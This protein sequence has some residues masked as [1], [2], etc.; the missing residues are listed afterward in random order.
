MQWISK[1]AIMNIQLIDVDSKIPNLALMQ[2]SAYHKARG[3]HVG[4]TISD[5]DRVYISCIFKKNASQAK[6]IAKMFPESKIFLGGSGL[7]WSW[8]PKKMQKIKPDYDLYPSNY[9]LGFTTRGCIRHCP[10][11]IVPKKE[12]P[13]CEWMNIQEFYD[14]R[15]D[16]V[17][18]L[19]NNILA[20][21]QRFME[22]TNFIIEHDLKVIEHGMDI[23]ILTPKLARRL[24]EIHWARPIKF[25]W[26]NLED[27]PKI[28]KGIKI[29]RDAG[30]NLRQNVE[31]YVLAGYNTTFNQDLYRCHRLKAEG[32]NAFVM[33]FHKND[34][35]INALARWANRKWL[36]WSIDFKDYDRVREISKEAQP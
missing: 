31:F 21:P 24:T 9:S 3:D 15:F 25:A 35:K 12:G 30:V 10:F 29:L 22:T 28:L 2:I 18:L 14:N 5:P 26:D 13:I 34:P 20:I 27:E 19:D 33:P 16:T 11:C 1:G 4:W 36:Y 8:L 6:G 23:R 7:S 32:T 17:M